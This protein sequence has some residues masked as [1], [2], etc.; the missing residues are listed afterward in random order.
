MKLPHVVLGISIT[1]FTWRNEI[2]RENR[3][4]FWCYVINVG[5]FRIYLIRE[6][7]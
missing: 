4:D 5:I 3:K 7:K 1:P 2:R 6:D